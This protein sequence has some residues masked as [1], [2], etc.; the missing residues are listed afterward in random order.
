MLLLPL[1]VCHDMFVCVTV[2]S[3]AS[4]HMRVSC[5]TFSL[6]L[7]PLS[8]TTQRNGRPSSALLITC[9]SSPVT[10]SQIQEEP[11]AP[12]DPSPVN[13]TETFL[14]DVPRLIPPPHSASTACVYLPAQVRLE[15]TLHEGEINRQGKSIPAAS[16]G[17]HTLRNRF[18][19]HSVFRDCVQWLNNV[20]CC[21]Q[22]I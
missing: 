7:N 18:I 4:T 5:L 14:K 1:S 20:Y 21:H 3:N 16:M 19:Q 9:H 17:F 22:R 8:L 13:E 10:P 11:C 12:V 2:I 15:E 6:P